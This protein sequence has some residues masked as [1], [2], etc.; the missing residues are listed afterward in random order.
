M[1][2]TH[3]PIECSPRH[4]RWTFGAVLPLYFLFNHFLYD[5]EKI[6]VQAK[7]SNLRVFS[8]IRK[9]RINITTKK[10]LLLC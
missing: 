10:G 8:L 3:M 9:L 1:H 5:S 6:L 4:A 7:F 2:G